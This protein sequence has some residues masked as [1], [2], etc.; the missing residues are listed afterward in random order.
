MCPFFICDKHKYGVLNWMIRANKKG[1]VLHL[2]QL[3][4]HNASEL[5][6]LF[7]FHLKILVFAIIFA[8]TNT[9][10]NELQITF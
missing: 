5:N 7:F 9:L 3:V 4:M 10:T 8:P 1:L 6:D 2:T